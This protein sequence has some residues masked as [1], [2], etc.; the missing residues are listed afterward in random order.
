M[1]SFVSILDPSFK[2]FADETIV[3]PASLAPGAVMARVHETAV[4]LYAQF[5]F[6]PQ[7]EAVV[8]EDGTTECINHVLNVPDENDDGMLL[9]SSTDAPAS[10]ASLDLSLQLT[11]C[12]D[13]APTRTE[14]RRNPR[15]TFCTELPGACAPTARNPL[16]SM[17][18]IAPDFVGA[19]R[20]FLVKG[21]RCGVCTKVLEFGWKEGEFMVVALS[22]ERMVLPGSAEHKFQQSEHGLHATSAVY[23]CFLVHLQAEDKVYACFSDLRFCVDEK[24]SKELNAL[25][26]HLPLELQALVRS[27]RPQ[28]QQIPLAVVAANELELADGCGTS[29][30]SEESADPDEYFEVLGT[31]SAACAESDPAAPVWLTWNDEQLHVMQLDSLV[32]HRSDVEAYAK[33]ATNQLRLSKGERAESAAAAAKRI[34]TANA[35]VKLAKAHAQRVLAECSRRMHIVEAE[36]MKL[37]ELLQSPTVH[38]GGDATTKIQTLQR[39]G[40]SST[41]SGTH[42]MD[43]SASAN[44]VAPPPKK[45]RLHAATKFGEPYAVL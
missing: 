36:R 10:L 5:Q 45:R 9:Y 34:C 41:S 42:V 31:A 37:A 35:N 32:Q 25:T 11:S 3:A 8:D 19:E 12:A 4:C 40:S 22:V 7:L 30:A 39:S 27:S 29:R 26:V 21:T 1:T 14:M 23:T 38:R 20:D 16:S 13:L 18:D 44:V 2:I 28:Q 6:K 33:E 24:G 15:T 17:I 43:D